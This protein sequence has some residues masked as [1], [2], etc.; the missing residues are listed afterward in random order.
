MWRLAIIAILAVV[1]V[2]AGPAFKDR[3]KLA[4]EDP[5]IALATAVCGL[6]LVY[7][8]FCFPG[9]VIPA[10]LGGALLIVSASALSIHPWNWGGVAVAAIGITLL[11]VEARFQPYGLAGIA[12]IVLLLWGAYAAVPGFKISLL[13]SLLIPWAVLTI[14][15]LRFAWLARQNKMVSF[16]L[17]CK[18]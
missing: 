15:L 7:V 6:V 12:A 18:I 13:A 3:S 14:V 16:C 17:F 2:A 8:E 11:F 9:L 1:L 5:N 10:S 4:L